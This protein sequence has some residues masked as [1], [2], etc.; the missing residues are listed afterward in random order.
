M[1]TIK[2]TAKMCL[3]ATVLL[4]SSAFAEGLSWQYVEVAYQQPSDHDIQGVEARFSGHVAKKWVLQG[5]VNRVRLKESAVD[6]EMSQTRFDVSMGRIF[7]LTNRL[8]ALVSAGYTRLEYETELGT[9][10]LDEGQHAGNVQFGLRTG[11]TDKFEAE[12]S[13]SMLFDD[14]DTSD[15][16]WNAR[17]RYRAIPVLSIVVGVSGI[18]SDVFDSNDILYEIGFRFDLGED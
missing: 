12:A 10:K 1:V 18:D 16:L 3:A 7:S 8:D 6:L 13:L 15:L 14:Q 9:L 4:A 2:T 11:I 5:R 17:L